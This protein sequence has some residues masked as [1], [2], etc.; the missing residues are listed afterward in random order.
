MFQ[1]AIDWF[2]ITRVIAV[3]SVCISLCSLYFTWKNRQITLAQE[4]RRQPRIVPFLVQSFYQN[5]NPSGDRHFAFQIRVSNPSDSAN[6]IASAEL[7]VTYLTT[8]HT[9]MTLV[10]LGND[11][12]ADF[13][14]EGENRNL[15][16]PIEIGANDTI[17]GWILFYLPSEM[18]VARSLDSYELRMTDTHGN[19]ARLKPS[20]VAEQTHEN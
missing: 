11:P 7:L 17:E 8:D 10:L 14:V 16:V 9:R 12:K 6:A 15:P 13:F 3:V 2:D 1:I 19:T 5:K 20:I 18:L 4:A